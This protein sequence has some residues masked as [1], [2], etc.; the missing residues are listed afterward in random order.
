MAHLRRSSGRRVPCMHAL[1][2]GTRA[3][4]LALAVSRRHLSFSEEEEKSFS[5]EEE[6]EE[7]EEE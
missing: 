5:E 2:S 7:E 1:S 3:S 4:T 6:V